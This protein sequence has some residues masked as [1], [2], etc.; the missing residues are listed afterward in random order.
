MTLFY[1]MFLIYQENSRNQHISSVKILKNNHS[2]ICIHTNRDHWLPA[3]I[4]V[5]T[6][7]SVL[8]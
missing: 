2:Y 3:V 7:T 5:E 1:I 4:V 6:P 8:S